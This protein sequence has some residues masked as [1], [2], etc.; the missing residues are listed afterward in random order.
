[1]DWD[2]ETE[3]SGG[4]CARACV[5]VCAGG[6]RMR[7][8]ARVVH[9]TICGGGNNGSWT[10]RL[11]MGQTHRFAVDGELHAGD[12]GIDSNAFCLLPRADVPNAA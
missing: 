12:G 7:V 2:T 4:V 3:T 1:M 9:N 5:C 11:A 6:V 10:H 8:Q